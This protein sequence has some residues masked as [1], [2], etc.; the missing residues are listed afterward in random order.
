MDSMTIIIG[1][2]GTRDGMTKEQEE[3]LFK[4][5]SLQMKLAGSGQFHHG[6]CVGSDEQAAGHAYR[7]GYQL[8]SHPPI[9]QTMSAHTPKYLHHNY[10]YKPKTFL[11]RNKDIVNVCSKLIATPAERYERL[12]SGTWSTVRY[13]RQQKTDTLVILP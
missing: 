11:E 7:I 8:F 9:I 12:R 1:F 3:K 6:D 2:T 10:V 13:A 4:E 5:L